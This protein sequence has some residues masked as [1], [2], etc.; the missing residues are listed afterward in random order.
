MRS[1]I[2][3]KAE[4]HQ[5]A[6]LAA[7]LVISALLVLGTF[8]A[9]A[10]AAEHRGGNQGR[11]D[12]PG[13]YRGDHAPPRWGGGYYLPPPVVYPPPPAV[14][15]SPYYGSPFYYPPPIVYGPGIGIFIR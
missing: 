6:T 8:V 1:I 13:G 15:G 14:Y 3:I 11:W 7:G 9:S 5:P 2:V 4:R 12:Y 10:S